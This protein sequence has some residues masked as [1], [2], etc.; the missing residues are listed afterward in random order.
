M[1]EIAQVSVDK[2]LLQM[3]DL[4]AEVA[5]AG[6]NGFCHKS[7]RELANSPGDYIL[8]V[9]SLLIASYQT[10]AA[11]CAVLRRVEERICEL[12]RLYVRPQFR[13]M[14]IG[15]IL[16]DSIISKARD[17]QY[18]RMR[19]VTSSPTHQEKSFYLSLGFQQIGYYE[20]SFSEEGLHMELDLQPAE[21]VQTRST[22]PPAKLRHTKDL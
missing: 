5:A 14:G 22:N 17:L 4:Y 16:A 8:P 9:G 19:V 13:R 18:Q 7:H 2:Y 21:S 6:S 12:K 15:L 3:N 10:Q 20:S 1:L 11:G